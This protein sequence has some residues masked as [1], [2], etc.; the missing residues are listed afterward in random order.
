MRKYVLLVVL[1][2]L[3]AIAYESMEMHLIFNP[4]NLQFYKITDP[5]DT[6]KIEYDKVTLGVRSAVVLGMTPPGTP[7]IGG[8]GR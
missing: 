2:S 6:D 8:V 7:S 5:L 4:E 1:L 3:S